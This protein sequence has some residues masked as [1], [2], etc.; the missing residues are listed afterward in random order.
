MI[1]AFFLS[2]GQLFD[3]RIGMVFVKSFL[4]T[5]LLFGALGVGLYFGLHWLSATIF[6]AGENS[7]ML[8]DILTIVVVLAAHWLLFRVIAI[9]VIGIFGDEVVEAVEAKHYPAAHA[10]VRHVP[11]AKSLRVGLRSGGRALVYNLVASPVYLIALPVAPFVFFIVNSWL[12]GRDFGD[13][14]AMRHMPDSELRAWRSR[15]RLRRLALGAVGTGMLLIPGV[16]FLAPVIGAAMTAH[17]F[18]LGR[19]S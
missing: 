3:R 19:K 2:L 18:H 6:G 14:V 12:L 10:Q 7:G 17:A 9:L 11:L 15:T 1:Q 4:L 13:M 5:L 16:N 8:A